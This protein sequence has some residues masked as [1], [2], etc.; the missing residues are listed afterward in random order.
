MDEIQLL[1]AENEA[2]KAAQ[3][4]YFPALGELIDRL[5][6]TQLKELLISTPTGIH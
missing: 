1:R 6:I 2:L 4:K 3:R 5:S